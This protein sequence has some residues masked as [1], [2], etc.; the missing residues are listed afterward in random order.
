MKFSKEIKAGLIAVLAIVSFVVLFQFMKGKSFFSTD[1][2]FY[3]QFD[4]VGGLATS[5]KV[6]INGLGVGQVDEIKP[7]TNKEGKISF[8]VKVLIKDNFSFS[9]SSTLEIY[10]PGM[11]SGKEVKINVVYGGDMAKSGDTLKGGNELSLMSSLGEKAGPISDQLQQA[12]KRVDSLASNANKILDDKNR[13]EIRALLINLNRTV[14]GFET[15]S[16]QV[17]SMLA[18]NDPKLQKLLESADKTMVTTNSAVEKYGDLAKN[19]D[20]K[21]LND[22]VANLDASI[23]KLNTV[24]SGIQNGEGSLGKLA[25]DEQLYQNISQASANLN[26]LLIDLKANPKRYINISVFGKSTKD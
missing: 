4:D 17:N 10:E 21:K 24:I 19:I 9:K 23:G 14:A 8:V 20:T 16:K 22:A 11:M 5:S 15:T 13:A 3:A 18:S 12:L 6:S 26:N 25:K 2:T 1:N 7:I